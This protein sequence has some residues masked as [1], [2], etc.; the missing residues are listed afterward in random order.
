M[1]N[2]SGSVLQNVDFDQIDEMVKMGLLGTIVDIKSK[3]GDTVKIIVE[4]L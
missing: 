3:D 2:K 4:Q 1:G